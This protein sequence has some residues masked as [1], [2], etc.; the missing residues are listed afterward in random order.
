MTAYARII[1]TGKN[2]EMPK[3]VTL[4]FGVGVDGTVIRFPVT[5]GGDEM[6][7][8]TCKGWGTDEW[9][10]RCEHC[11]GDRIVKTE[12]DTDDGSGCLSPLSVGRTVQRLQ[13]V[14]PP[15]S[16]TKPDALAANVS[17]CFEGPKTHIVKRSV[18]APHASHSPVEDMPPDAPP[19]AFLEAATTIAGLIV[20]GAIAYLFLVLA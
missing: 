10:D 2:G 14:R 13:T 17:P 3:T 9:A 18:L 4:P 16:G 11:C 5:I 12:Q 1:T 8:P 19:G 6:I 15:S 7:C 20:F